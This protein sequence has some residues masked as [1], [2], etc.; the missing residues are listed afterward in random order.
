MNEKINHTPGPWDYG[1]D[2]AEWGAI[3]D[4][5]DGTEYIYGGDI[6][7]S[8]GA[9][10]AGEQH[11][12]A[13]FIVLACNAHD[14]ILAALEELLAACIQADDNEEL[15][16]HITGEMLEQAAAAIAKAKGETV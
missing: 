6:D 7:M 14:D 12:N 16:G 11:A 1:H 2:W 13:K 4:C 3:A 15:D 9:R 8:F 5:G 10:P